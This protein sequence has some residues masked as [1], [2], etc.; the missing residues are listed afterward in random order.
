MDTMEK[1]YCCDRPNDNTALWAALSNRRDGEMWNNPMM[2]L[3]WM[4]VMRYMNGGWDG[5][6]GAENFNSRAISQL[7][8]TVDNNHNNDLAMQAIKGNT[9]AISDLAS[10]MNG[11]RGPQRSIYLT[12]KPNL[13]LGRNHLGSH[14][15][16]RNRQILEIYII[17][18]THC[19]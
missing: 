7:Q 17:L 1:V 13:R 2:Y 9:S 16:K 14:T 15:N 6:A 11:H 12:V 8:S 10:V 5:N 19:Q 3:V 4:W 18:I